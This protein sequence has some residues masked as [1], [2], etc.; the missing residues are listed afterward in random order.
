MK[1]FIFSK[2]AGLLAYSWQLYYQMNF[3]K[4][5]FR[6][7]LKPPMLPP[8]IDLR[9]PPS[10]FEESPPHVLNTYG[11]TWGEGDGSQLSVPSKLLFKLESFY[12]KD[13]LLLPP[14]WNYVSFWRLNMYGWE[15]WEW[16]Y[17]LF[18]AFSCVLNIA[19]AIKNW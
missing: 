12:K 5:I 11:K 18:M 10:N 9:P 15:Q 8:C 19:D 16:R 14:F 2:F 4:G 17:M 13:F 3:F 1:K 6:Q 7:H